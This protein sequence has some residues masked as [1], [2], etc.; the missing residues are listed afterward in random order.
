M[1]RER[2]GVRWKKKGEKRK[3]KREIQGHRD[4]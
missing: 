3:R 1:E 2:E 4:D